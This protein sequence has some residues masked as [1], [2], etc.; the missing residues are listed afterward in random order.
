MR[1]VGVVNPGAVHSLVRNRN[2]KKLFL[3][4]EI[5]AWRKV[6]RDRSRQVDDTNTNNSC[7]LIKR[8]EI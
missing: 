7:A 3:A 8:G 4:E 6:V 5:R 1:L 2:G